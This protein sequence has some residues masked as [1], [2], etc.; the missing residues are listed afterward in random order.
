MARI[1]FVDDEIQYHTGTLH[2]LR[3]SLG[4]EIDLAKNSSQAIQ[5]LEQGTYDLMILDIMLAEEDTYSTSVERERAG[6]ELLR[7]LR[8]GEIAGENTRIPVV[9]YSAVANFEIQQEVKA[10]GISA[11]LSN[12]VFLK[13]LQK[14]VGLALAAGEME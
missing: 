6:L 4:H 13:E 7:R 11:H 10:L 2:F 8:T 5:L 12:P 3:K 14:A 1:L 9:V